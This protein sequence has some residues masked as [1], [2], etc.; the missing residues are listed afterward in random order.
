MIGLPIEVLPYIRGMQLALVGYS[1]YTKG[2]RVKVDKMV[3]LEITRSVGRVRNHMSN[4]M[5]N[6]FK[7]G[8]IK[9]A[10][11]AKQCIE[12][13]DYLIEDVNKAVTG[14]DHA[15]LSGQRSASNRDLKRLIKHDHDVINMVTKAVNLGNA[16]EQSIAYS[17]ENSTRLILLTS[18]LV[19]SC[20]GFFSARANL[21]AGLNQRK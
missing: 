8:N 14:M 13:C 21:L 15:F 17:G 10:K 12:Q 3:R 1:G 9:I 4:I 11:I 5:T 19:T 2:S 6:Q 20:K 7:I 18:Q 16:A